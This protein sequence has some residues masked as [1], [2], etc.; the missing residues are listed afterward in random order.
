MGILSGLALSLAFTLTRSF[1]PGDEESFL[2]GGG[3]PASFLA[4]FLGGIST[5]LGSFCNKNIR[6]SVFLIEMY[7]VAVTTLSQ[8]LSD[9]GSSSRHL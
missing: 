1:L 6:S 4:R 8:D 3:V 9:R 2:F 5:N 7:A